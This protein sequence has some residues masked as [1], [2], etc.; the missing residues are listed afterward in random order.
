MKKLSTSASR[1][2]HDLQ[3]SIRGISREVGLGVAEA[4]HQEPP[5]GEEP[6][7]YAERLTLGVLRAIDKGFDEEHLQ[8]S[9]ARVVEGAVEAALSA[10]LARSP[11]I[12]EM[13]AD[14][15]RAFARGAL[16]E[17]RTELGAKGEGP[18]TRSLATSTRRVAAEGASALA[19]PL[20]LFAVA[21]GF[22]LMG[23][24]LFRGSR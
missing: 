20:V 1:L 19:T 23:A 3:A 15:A 5:D 16:S 13:S 22:G 10:G 24:L 4:L 12:Q 14:A 7:Q 18:L 17:L 9:L 21:A 11:R 2:R 8:R 6:G